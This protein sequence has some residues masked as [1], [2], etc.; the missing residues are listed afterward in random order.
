MN[1]TDKTPLPN[2]QIWFVRGEQGN[3]LAS[4]FLEQGVVSLG[5]FIGR[6]E[7]DEPKDQIVKRL[8]AEFRDTPTATLTAR[9]AQFKRFN[10]QMAVGD[11]VATYDSEH[12]LCHIGIIRAL[13]I[14]PPQDNQ[15]YD[16]YGHDYVHSVEWLHQV[17]R[18]DLSEYTWRRI[19]I[20]LTLHRL[21]AEASAELRGLC[22]R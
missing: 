14:P 4:Y 13:L 17:L 20:P 10:E 1:Q 3:V 18:D 21:S 22:A 5:W 11:V 19:A 12:R 15:A 8:A 9:A 6:L 7:P 16:E 2:S